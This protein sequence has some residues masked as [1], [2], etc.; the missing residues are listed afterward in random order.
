MNTLYLLRHAIS[1]WV[2]Q[3]LS[4]KDRPLA[5]RGRRDAKRLVQHLVQLGIE[6][7]LVL[8][9]SARRTRETL[10]LVRPAL[11]LTPTVSLE[12]ELYAAS[13]DVLLARVCAV[14]EAVDSVMLIGHNPGLQQL[15]IV[16]ASDSSELARIK[17]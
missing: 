1:S 10:E 16:L 17:A 14:P 8:C 15:A 11:G 2:D 3:T 13:S 6:P 5:P 7:E 12:A 4:D 9:S